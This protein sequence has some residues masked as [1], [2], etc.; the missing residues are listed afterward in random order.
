LEG[1]GGEGNGTGLGPKGEDGGGTN[2]GSV[3]ITGV[4]TNQLPT[5][6]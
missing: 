3:I 4:P 1:P 2:L 6:K 5:L